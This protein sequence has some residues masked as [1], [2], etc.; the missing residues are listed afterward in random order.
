M[1]KIFTQNILSIYGENGQNW[2]NQLPQILIELQKI[3]NIEQL[4]PVDNLSY[5]YVLQG[6]RST[7]D[8]IVKI[9]FR[10][11][12]LAR[13]VEALQHF[14]SNGCVELLEY[15]KQYSAILLNRLN[16]GNMLL[17]LAKSDPEKAL[18]IA[19]DIAKKLHARAGDVT[20]FKSITHIQEWTKILDESWPI[21]PKDT[22]NKAK[23]LRDKLLSQTHQQVVLHGDLHNENILQ[24]NDQWISIDPK[25]VIGDPA[26]DLWCLVRDNNLIDHA[27]KIMNID[28]K[29]IAQWGFVMAV[30][31]CCWRIEDNLDLAPFMKYVEHFEQYL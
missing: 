23:S 18:T 28:T 10:T 25:G 26:I 14:N 21:L 19:C 2:L 16:P 8:I 9:S 17:P 15:N 30:I 3:W 6:K 27:A 20:Y 22:L 4:S 13:E 29:H 24:S 12:A 11:D 5:N 31:S 1:N 7:Q